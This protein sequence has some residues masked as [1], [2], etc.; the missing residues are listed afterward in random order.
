V[1]V[2]DFKG[3]Q[4]IYIHQLSV[5]FNVSALLNDS[6]INLDRVTIEGAN[7]NLIRNT[8]DGDLNMNLF[9]KNL[10]SLASSRSPSANKKTPVFSIDD[11]YISALMI[12]RKIVSGIVLIIIISRFL[13]SMRKLKI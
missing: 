9:I 5:D 2:I 4:M 12:P 10:R 7:V 11:I 6:D 8:E 13:I 3:N 1:E